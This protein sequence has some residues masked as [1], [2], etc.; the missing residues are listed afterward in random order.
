MSKKGQ[1][2]GTPERRAEFVEYLKTL[3]PDSP[4]EYWPWSANRKTYTAISVNFQ[5][6]RAHRWV[7]EQV[8]GPLPA[9]T[10][11]GATGTLVLHSCDHPP[12][13][14]PAHLSAGS[15][16]QNAQD[17][18]RKGRLPGVPHDVRYKL[19]DDDVVR[20]RTAFSLGVSQ[21]KL[22]QQFGVSISTVNS[23]VHDRT[24]V[25]AAVYT[26]ISESDIIKIRRLAKA[27]VRLGTIAK[28]WGVSRTLVSEVVNARGRYSDLP[29]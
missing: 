8:H 5:K 20:V 27:S 12:C 2:I 4:C 23:I 1:Q 19:S 7:Y 21:S 25:T 22:A 29:Q 18:S 17:A 16:L 26:R 14:N 6:V 28:A 15:A 24:R 10:G 13:V 9:R 11:R 3:G